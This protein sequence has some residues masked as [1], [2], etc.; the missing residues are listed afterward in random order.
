MTRKTTLSLVA[1][2]LL[3]TLLTAC[4][5]GGG[6]GDNGNVLS[7]AKHDVKN[8]VSDVKE[9]IQ[10]VNVKI[11]HCPFTGAEGEN[12]GKVEGT[13]TVTQANAAEGFKVKALAGALSNG[14]DEDYDWTWKPTVTSSAANVAAPL[15]SDARADK[16]YFHIGT[17]KGGNFVAGDVITVDV[18]VDRKG[19][20]DDQHGNASCKLT[21]I[22]G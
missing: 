15:W 17:I 10:A 5:G 8:F 6:S 12:E 14:K 1:A 16:D 21:V 2:A 7:D 22:A 13:L 11:T 20:A 4:G 19:H 3:S 9:D 18:H